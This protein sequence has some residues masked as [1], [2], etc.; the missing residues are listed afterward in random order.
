MTRPRNMTRAELLVWI[1]ARC[2]RA[3]SGCLLWPG[4]AALLDVAGRV[5]ACRG[6]ATCRDA[7]RRAP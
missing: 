3:P 6:C 1:Q 2:E 7:E 4:R 5:R